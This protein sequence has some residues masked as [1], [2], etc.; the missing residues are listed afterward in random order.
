MNAVGL[1]WRCVGVSL[2]AQMQ[3]RASFVIFTVGQFLATGVEFLALWALFE[4]F[5]ALGSW[6]LPEAA[7]CYG[8]VSVAFATGE[9][10]SRG[11]DTFAHLVRAGGFDR[12]LLRPRT[13]AFQ[14]FAQELQLTRIGRLAQGLAVLLWAAGAID[15]QWTFAK[16][17]L[18]PVS[19]PVCTSDSWA[20]DGQSG[21]TASKSGS[22]QTA[23][24]HRSP[25]SPEV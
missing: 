14:L 10:I 23:E 22:P 6:R 20:A 12:L 7:L 17:A 25:S 2:R 5:G 4:R 15:V 16:V 1:Y 11:F 21:S 8:M 3:Y 13:A 9:L 19:I 24:I 18:V